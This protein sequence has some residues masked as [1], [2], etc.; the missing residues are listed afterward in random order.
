[1]GVGEKART[2]NKLVLSWYQQYV[3]FLFLVMDMEKK[4]VGEGENR[5]RKGN[6]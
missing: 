5:E 3:K 4:K 1:M 6:R 2:T